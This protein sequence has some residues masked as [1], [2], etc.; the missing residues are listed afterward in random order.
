MFYFRSFSE[1]VMWV[2]LHIGW[3]VYYSC[4]IIQL[5]WNINLLEQ[6]CVYVALTKQPYAA[7]ISNI[8]KKAQLMPEPTLE[9]L[10]WTMENVL[11]PYFSLAFHLF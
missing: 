4:Q 9:L 8:T 7:P 1:G 6:T 10:K 3:W 11:Q 2:S 5:K